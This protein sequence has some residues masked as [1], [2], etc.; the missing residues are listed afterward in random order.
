MAIDFLGSVTFAQIRDK[1]TAAV[2]E[3]GVSEFPKVLL[4]PGGE[5]EAIVYD[6]K[7]AKEP[8][9]KFFKSVKAPTEEPK[10]SEAAEEENETPVEKAKEV[11]GE[12]REFPA[13]S[14]V[15]P[16]ILLTEIL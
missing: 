9:L 13:L 11:P 4:L 8:L 16:S 10:A 12:T 7:L 5:Q 6:G 3:F 15:K 14:H 2:E 1:E